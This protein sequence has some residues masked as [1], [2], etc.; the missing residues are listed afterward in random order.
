MRERFAHRLV[1]GGRLDPP[2][3]AVTAY[4]TRRAG[5]WSRLW[6][7]GGRLPAAWSGLLAPLERNVRDPTH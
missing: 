3:D 5:R 2:T 1:R 6:A 7:A 4:G